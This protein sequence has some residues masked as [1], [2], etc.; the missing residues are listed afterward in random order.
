MIIDFHT[1]IF[2]DKIAAATIA[3]LEKK[4]N[5]RAFENGKAEG[6]IAAADE[7]GIDIAVNLPVLT[8]PSQFESVNLFAKS[9]NEKEYSGAKI[10]SFAGM[11]PDLEEPEEKIKY[12]AEAGFAGFKIHPDYQ[13]TF[14]DDEK[15][16]RI[17]A[18]AKAHD[19]TVITHAGV[20][21]AYRDVEV[22][23]TPRRV[24]NLLDKIGGYSKLV[25]AHLGGNEMLTD[26]YNELAGEDVYFD[27]ALVLS[28]VTKSEF[29]SLL[30]KHGEDRMLF[31]TDCPWSS[32]ARDVE[33]IRSFELP[34]ETERKIFSGNAKKLLKI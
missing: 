3:A 5:M 26:V 23:C 21:A 27:T 20:D 28:R 13:G 33:M 8:K 6:L 14:F 29:L 22:K 32:I 31:G 19:L 7:A 17:I 30:Q 9:F 4:G 16:V 18:A 12:I 11:H 1:H 15:Y 34:E 10:I 2:P 25:L 24:L